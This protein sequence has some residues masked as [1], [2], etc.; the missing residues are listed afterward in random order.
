MTDAQ[1]TAI[2]TSILDILESMDPDDAEHLDV[3]HA[4]VGNSKIGSVREL[5]A[6]ADTTKPLP[7]GGSGSVNV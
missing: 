1:L 6:A 4:R 3:E 5:I 2:L 7:F